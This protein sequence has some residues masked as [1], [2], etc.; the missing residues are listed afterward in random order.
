ME[1]QNIIMKTGALSTGPTQLPEHFQRVTLQRLV[2]DGPSPN[3]FMLCMM[4][5]MSAAT[6]MQTQQRSYNGGRGLQSNVRH[7]RRLVLM[8]L[9]SDAGSN[10]CMIFTG[11]G[12]CPRLMANVETRDNGDIRESWSVSPF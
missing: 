10:V 5:G 6:N 2:A 12:I 4:L 8:C 9:E 3:T 11:N 1:L 7:T